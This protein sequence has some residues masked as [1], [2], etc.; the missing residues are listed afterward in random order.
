MKNFQNLGQIDIRPVLHELHRQPDLW[1]ADTYLRDYPQGPFGD[2]ETV[3]IRFPSASV[4]EL[5]RGARDPHE[6]VW[7]DGAIRAPAARALALWLMAHVGGE[8]L[9]RV[10]INKLRPGGKI[11]PHADTPIHADY[12]DR[13]HVV[14]Q[15]A[16]GA[17]FRCGE[18]TVY[19]PPGSL[20]HFRNEL[21]HEVTNNSADDRIHMIVDI[22]ITSP[23]PGELPTKPVQEVK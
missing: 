10:M 17:T 12:W 13:Y 7:M 22:R 20:W 18:E 23:T 6:C 11:Y 3:F 15:S 19:M 14:L 2:T 1:K 21:E 8:R 9:G 5:E 16:P 4:T